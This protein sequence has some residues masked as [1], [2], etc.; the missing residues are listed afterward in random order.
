MS[1]WKSILLQT[2]ILNIFPAFVPLSS[3]K[4]I[5]E[6]NSVRKATGYIPINSLWIAKFFIKLTND[7]ENTCLTLDCT[8]FHPNGPGRLR[9]KAENPDIQPVILM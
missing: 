3:L 6:A 1:I 4:N 2:N 7:G 8:G 9:T 5:L